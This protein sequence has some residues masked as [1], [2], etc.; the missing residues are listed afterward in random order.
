VGSQAVEEHSSRIIPIEP[1]ASGVIL[2]RSAGIRLSGAHPQGALVMAKSY[3]ETMLG[4]NEKIVHATRQHWF[5]L[6]SSILAE[7]VVIL[8]LLIGIPLLVALTGGLASFLFI[9]VLIPAAKGLYDLL[10]WSNRQYIVTNRRVI[11]I[12]GIF[13]K[14]VTDSSL[15]KV[16]DLKL[17]QSAL[18]RMF[19]YGD[20]EI[21]TAS[22]LG[23]N[24]FKQI[25][26]PIRFKTAMLDAKEAMPRS[27]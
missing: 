26:D 1:S 7:L 27:D 11:Q 25:A 2:P 3:V 19:N 6:L 20:I 14:S 24:L 8:I 5:L 16:T 17:E 9:L 21:L 13:N 15:E 22:E 18:G 4:Q 23:V 12:S 10:I